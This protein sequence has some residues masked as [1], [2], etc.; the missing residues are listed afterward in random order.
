MPKTSAALLLFRHGSDG[1]EVLIA[2]MGGPFWARKDAGAWSIPKGEYTDEEPLAAARREF[3]EEMGSPPPGGEPVALGT[4]K[5]SGGKSV[6]TFAVEGDFDLAGF[7]SNTFELEWPRGSG[8]V[9]EFPEVDRAAWVPVAVAREKLVKGQVP[10]LDAL[11]EHLG[12]N[13]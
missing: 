7:R 4:V 5:Q 1:L 2:H 12:S 3:A 8:R 6:T 13:A 10:V 11:V 9:Q